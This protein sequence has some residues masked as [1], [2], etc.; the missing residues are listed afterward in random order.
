MQIEIVAIGTELLLGLLTDTNS[1]HI[2]QQ[3]SEIGVDCYFQ[4]R[5]GDNVDR[6]KIALEVALSRN[7]A[8]ICCGG[9]GPTSDDLTR[10]AI[11][12]LTGSELVFDQSIWA[13]IESRFS[14]VG[15]KPAE[16]NKVQAMVPKGT[17]TIPQEAGTAPGLICP[18]GD[19]VI[20]AVPGVPAEM[21]EMLKSTIL[22]D[23]VSRK[24]GGETLLFKT[25]RT[26]GLPESKVAEIISEHIEDL[27]RLASQ[28]SPSS[29]MLHSP[30]AKT[31]I[32]TIAFLA[33]STEGVRIRLGVKSE[34]RERAVQLLAQEEEIIRSFLG[35]VIF[36]ADEESMEE[37]VA[38]LLKQKKLTLATAESLTGGLVSARI[39]N[40]AGA[41]EFFLGG[42]VS[43]ATDI[44][45]KFLGVAS[46]VV[47]DTAVITMA[48]E[49][50]KLFGSDIGIATSG[51]AGPTSQENVEPGNVYIGIAAD[52]KTEA[53]HF[54]LR[55]DRERIR[56]T[57]TMHAL[58]ILRRHLIK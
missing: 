5:V 2:A 42:L 20:Y 56:Q 13:K 50:R 55:G 35:D 44:K 46:H 4:T 19:K 47:S 43:Y 10:N 11:A 54:K 48:S 38:K 7:D 36:A 16:I 28:G 1:T 15:H 8:V 34:N 32:P 27:D 39:V 33:S 31:E 6:I 57:G 12:E 58:D 49:V 17:A 51:V 21:K 25:L 3:L 37:A 52:D 23:L 24:K 41:S 14:A 18:V 22:P 26:W 45:K 53:Y 40:V 30:A 29:A 9:L